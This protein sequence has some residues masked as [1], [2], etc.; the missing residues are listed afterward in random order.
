VQLMVKP[1]ALNTVTSLSALGR[2]MELLE[3]TGTSAS[4]QP[5]DGHCSHE[6]CTPRMQSP[7]GG[8]GPQDNS[9]SKSER[10]KFAPY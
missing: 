8:M 3:G 10:S 9:K 4:V 2:L 7:G 5:T 6:T 1:G